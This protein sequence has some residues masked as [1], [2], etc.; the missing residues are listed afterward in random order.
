MFWQTEILGLQAHLVQ[1]EQCNL[2]WHSKDVGLQTHWGVNTHTPSRKPLPMA[3]HKVNS[4]CWILK[5]WKAQLSLGSCSGDANL[6]RVRTLVLAPAADMMDELPAKTWTFFCITPKANRYRKTWQIF[7]EI[8]LA[9]LKYIY[10]HIPRFFCSLT[11]FTAEDQI[12]AVFTY[13]SNGP[14]MQ[15]KLINFQTTPASTQA[16]SLQAEFWH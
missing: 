9:E 8:K 16:A 10:Q 6:T 11:P 7:D 5:N 2:L 14:H 15:S 13:R 12:I 4:K 1:K 3:N